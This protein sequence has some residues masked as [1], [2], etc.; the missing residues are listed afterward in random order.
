MLN[1]LNCLIENIL[2]GE[3][4]EKYV[5]YGGQ[6]ACKQMFSKLVTYVGDDAIVIHME[7]YRHPLWDSGSL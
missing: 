7:G 6:V 2:I 3:I 1:L 5:N 4:Y